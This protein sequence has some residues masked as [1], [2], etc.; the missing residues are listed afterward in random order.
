[1]ELWIEGLDEKSGDTRT[2]TMI[3]S[4]D[5]YE[6]DWEDLAYASYKEREFE[7]LRLEYAE[8]DQELRDYNKHT[9]QQL[10]DLSKERQSLAR[11]LWQE[12]Q[13]DAADDTY[14]VDLNSKTSISVPR[15]GGWDAASSPRN[16]TRKD[17]RINKK[18][19]RRATRSL[20]NFAVTK[21]GRNPCQVSG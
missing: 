2:K 3:A 12:Y 14:E 13:F 10:R 7:S 4:D 15:E 9:D 8:I 5:S 20:N 16:L 1:M 17:K 21:Q 18:Q 11:E 6:P 19:I